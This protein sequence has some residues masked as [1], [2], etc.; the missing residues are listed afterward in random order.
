MSA[1][2]ATAGPEAPNGTR[3][4]ASDLPPGHP[5]IAPGISGK[6]AGGS[7]HGVVTPLPNEEAPAIAWSVPST[8]ESAPNPNAMRI[9]TYHI[10]EAQP[11]SEAA[12]A[13]VA[14]AG[15]S[16]AANIDRWVGQFTTLGKDIRSDS[17]IGGLKVHVIQVEGTYVSG[18]MMTGTAPASHQEWALVG[19]VVETDG[20]P[21]F[22]K[23]TGPKAAVLRARPAFDAWIASIKAS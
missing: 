15:G 19:A 2:E 9:A 13:F 4:A 7:P 18:G 11:G 17:V 1:V 14:R 8:W 21:Y 22:F 20:S 12:E 16:P 5:A 23:L 3:A 10:P 6:H